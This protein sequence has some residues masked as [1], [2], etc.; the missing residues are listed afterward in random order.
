MLGTQPLRENFP[1]RNRIISG[2]SDGVIVVEA[3]EK[4]GSLIT[5]R[6]AHD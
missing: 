5:A 2:L 6:Y 1:R 3:S 4:S